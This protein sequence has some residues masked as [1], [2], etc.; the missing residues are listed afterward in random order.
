[1]KKTLHKK[2]LISI[3]SV[4][5]A[6]TLTFGLASL[7]LQ[8][9]VYAATENVYGFETEY[10]GANWY[11]VVSR[12]PISDGATSVTFKYKITEQSTTLSAFFGIARGTFTGNNY[13]GTV[14]ATAN[15]DYFRINSSTDYTIVGAEYT[16]TM[17]LSNFA[18]T[19]ISGINN[20]TEISGLSLPTLTT[21]TDVTND[22]VGLLLAGA[23]YNAKYEISCYDNLGKD[24]QITTLSLDNSSVSSVLTAPEDTDILTTGSLSD[25]LFARTSTITFA[26]GNRAHHGLINFEATYVEN[27]NDL[28]S[29]GSSDGNAIHINLA[30]A[31]NSKN[32][33]MYTLQFGGKVKVADMGENQKLVIKWMSNF[34]SAKL[35]YIYSNT[36]TTKSA[37]NGVSLN[38]SASSTFVE[39]SLNKTQCALLADIDGYVEGFTILMVGEDAS[40][41]AASLYIDEIYLYEEYVNE[42][43][44]V[45]TF[46][47]DYVDDLAWYGVVTRFAVSENARKVYFNYKIVEQNQ[48]PGL[49]AYARG[50]FTRNAN[51]G[52]ANTDYLRAGAPANLYIVGAEYTIVFDLSNFSNTSV[53]GKTASGDEITI[54]ALVFTSGIDVTNDRF[55]LFLGGNGYK[56]KYEISCYD[57]TGKDLAI[58]T[59]S[60]E[61]SSFTDNLIATT[62]ENVITEGIASDSIF[63]RTG[64]VSFANG[65]R[66]QHSLINSE[67]SYIVN[68][69]ELK[70]KGS[71]DGN[72]IQIDLA[73][74]NNANNWL[75]Y[76]IKFAVKINV[77][78][79]SDG[80]QMIFKILFTLT[81]SS[82]T[83]MYLFPL[84][85]NV[86]NVVAGSTVSIPVTASETFSEYSLTKSQMLA[87][88]DA[89][90]YIDGLTLCV[91]G[92]A[93]TNANAKIYLDHIELVTE[94]A[95]F[96]NYSITLDG[97]I[98]LNFYFSIPQTVIDDSSAKVT[99]SIN[100]K[101]SERTVTEQDTSEELY[102]FTVDVSP[103]DYLEKVTVKI[104]GSTIDDVVVSKS[105][106]DYLEYIIN[107]QSG[108]YENERE[109]CLAMKSYC[110]DAYNHFNSISVEEKYFEITKEIVDSYASV[111]T[112]ELPDGVS[113]KAIGMILESETT[114]RVFF[115]AESEDLLDG[116]KLN[117]N[118][119]TVK[120]RFYDNGGVIYYV[121]IENV[122]AKD[123]DTVYVI[124]LGEF[125]I[126][127]SA[128]TYVRASL[129][130][131][132]A[133]VSLVNLT[134]SLYRY[135]QKANEYFEV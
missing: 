79:I 43:P 56:S 24:L 134:K 67:A 98:G 110:I 130:L 125:S 62:D 80:T 34:T 128:M 109:L 40:S 7:N 71:K 121:D 106:S 116:I 32:W 76:S 2:V 113:V 11:G 23:N 39:Y 65:N 111:R 12:L 35:T 30:G 95:E 99:I 14:N 105:V 73:G 5:T 9:K 48:T 81:K 54:P 89:D 127:V 8:S 118:D 119:V 61:N 17:N 33:I 74:V 102:K 132:D 131:Q 114:L 50:T 59:L 104:S 64:Q 112:G 10:V 129:D 77:N 123:L 124:T 97:K 82:N 135:N 91:I 28:K 49:L 36:D 94:Q 72:A 93:S 84:R 86:R 122:S 38:I 85:D 96:D 87:L 37:N 66:T 107:D 45:Y 3:L 53:S 52:S 100:G 120:S 31:V 46:E 42:N 26:N 126:C 69:D 58:T 21:G 70:T 115:S 88:A 22:H 68:S 25:V 57:D 41:T 78:D 27:S 55:G 20:G 18:N 133:S 63:V 4:I 101:T 92:E 75:L 47:T 108:T 16:V 51:G 117:G 1:M 103:K 90:G 44:V 15:I 29:K 60:I 19:T 13:S 6:F 83:P